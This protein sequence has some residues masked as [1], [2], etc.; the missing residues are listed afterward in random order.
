M[1]K[2]IT[3]ILITTLALAGNSQGAS[4]NDLLLKKNKPSEIEDC[5]EKF[6]RASFA[7]NQ[8][9]DAAIFKPVASAYRSLPSPVRVGVGNSLDNLSNLITIPNNILQGD[10]TAAGVNTG[11]F[12]INTTL[13]ILG[14]LQTMSLQKRTEAVEIYGPSGIEEF[15]TANIKVLNFGLPFPVF[16]TIVD[17]GNVV[18]EKNYQKTIRF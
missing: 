4:D 16:I 7:L 15:I 2:K 11:R 9:L 8:T 6:N 3:I 12:V 1:L 5:S 18:K 13:G 10:L 14:L 17:E